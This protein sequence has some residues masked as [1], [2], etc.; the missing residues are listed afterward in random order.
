MD[1]I[2][3][4]A[5]PLM[6]FIKPA[7]S[8]GLAFILGAILIALIGKDPIEI[9]G[10]M[11]SMSLGTEYGIG[12][13]LFRMTPLILTGLAVA[14]PFQAGLF[15]IGGEGQALTGTFACALVGAWLPPETSVVIA[16]PLCLIAAMTAGGIWGGIAGGLR[17]RFG[18]N[19]VIL[20]IMLNFIAAALVGYL[21][22]N[23]FAVE[24]TMRT[25]EI[26][27]GARIARLDAMGVFSRA[28]SN[29]SLLLS[30]AI[31]A[32]C[33]VLVFKTKFG[34]ELRAV[35]LNADAAKY[36]GIRANQHVFF[37]M[38]LAGMLAGLVGANYVMGYKYYFESGGISGVGFLGIAV[39][40]LAGSNPLWIIG[41]AFLFGLL[42]YGGLT[43]NADVPKEIFLILQAAVILFIIAGQK[44]SVKK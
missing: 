31:T 33:Y 32:L 23:H 15:N 29:F 40:M 13:V 25:K 7:A 44:I 1:T 22:T 41:S 42:D 12:Q 26:A 38:L 28:P 17:V 5:A 43:I 27:Q 35:G 34:Y 21:L 11:I 18:I 4:R 3:N 24:A 39:A 20:T 10:K 16:V 8:V 36:A 9:Y 30:M 14:I 6:P 37:S 19:E 2:V